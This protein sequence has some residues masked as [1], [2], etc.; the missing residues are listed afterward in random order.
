MIIPAVYPALSSE[1]KLSKQNSRTS[2]QL[3]RKESFKFLDSTFMPVY[4]SIGNFLTGRFGYET[5]ALNLAEIKGI[6]GIPK[7]ILNNTIT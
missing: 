3:I 1:Q 4:G 7:I 2:R 6:P 5:G